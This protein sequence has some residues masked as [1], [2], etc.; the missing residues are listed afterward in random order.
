MAHNISFFVF[1]AGNFLFSFFFCSENFGSFQ[2]NKVYESRKETHQTFVFLLLFYVS[3]REIYISTFI[4]WF[5]IICCSLFPH[6]ST[7]LITCFAFQGVER[8]ACVFQSSDLTRVGATSETDETKELTSPIVSS[9]LVRSSFKWWNAGKW[10]GMMARQGRARMRNQSP[11]NNANFQRK[12][13]ASLTRPFL[14]VG[15]PSIGQTEKL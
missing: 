4:F 14:D 12:S 8:E 15:R 13:N 3:F 6:Q 10:H 7:R 1:F 11:R 9:A 5:L 2:N